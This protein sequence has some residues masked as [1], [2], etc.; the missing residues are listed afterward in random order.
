MTVP[1]SDPTIEAR[2]RVAAARRTVETEANGLVALSQAL[3]GELG[4]AFAA[5]VDIILAAEGRVIVT[6]MGKS[7]HVGRKIAS[8]FASTG[9]PA[10]FVHPGEAS[11]GDLG[12]IGRTDVIL[13]LS[14][15]GETT[16]LRDLVDYS[17]RFRVPLVAITSSADSTLGRAADVVLALPK[18][19][20][21]C[22]M[23]LAPTS[24]TVLQLS[25]GD[26]LAV[27]LLEGRGF[28][29]LDFK[30]FH[31]GGKLG[32]NLRFVRDLM[33]TGE[34]VPLVAAGTLMS[35]AILTMSA[36]GFGCVGIAGAEGELLG[37]VTDGD[38]RR[39]MATDLM[40][41]SVDQ[42]MTRG[43]K[44][45][46]PDQLA[47]EALELMETKKIT[48]LFAVADRRPVGILHLHD[49]LRSGLA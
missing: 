36:K 49:I 18:V 8:T 33:H 38:L 14:W 44:T 29:P 21:A 37:I 26:A 43:P 39:H 13:A 11:H 3:D 6:G 10:H 34:A 2:V 31:P 23:G 24:S 46:R 41:R 47:A 22:P 42:V 12:M 4:A 5:A 25:L 15:S 7:G 40:A 16:E 30:V 45:T 20:E 32:A 27:A 28:T 1:A 17:R 35:E 19:T 48:A 9:T